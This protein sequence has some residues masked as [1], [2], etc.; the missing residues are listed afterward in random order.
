MAELLTAVVSP[1][2]QD[3]SASLLPLLSPSI[4]RGLQDLDD[5]V[6]AVAAS[7][8]LPVANQLLSI[9]PNQ[10]SAHPHSPS[11]WG[12]HDYKAYQTGHSSTQGGA[13]LTS[14]PGTVDGMYIYLFHFHL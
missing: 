10:V 7:S 1:S 11:D 5:D 6:R 4:L 3:M 9:L 8:L 2:F 14:C 12:C 13:C